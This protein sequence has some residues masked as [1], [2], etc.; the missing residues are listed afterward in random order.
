VERRDARAVPA[1]GGPGGDPER[2]DEIPEPGGAEMVDD[3]EAVV[4]AD[5]PGE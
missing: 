5:G 3:L 1:L 2:L 4:L